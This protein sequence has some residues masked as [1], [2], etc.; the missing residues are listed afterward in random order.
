MEDI[1]SRDMK[2]VQIKEEVRGASILPK[3]VPGWIA[4]DAV[5]YGIRLYT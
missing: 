2:S 5:L 1:R 4:F 3:K